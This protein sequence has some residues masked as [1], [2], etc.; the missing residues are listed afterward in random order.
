[1]LLKY[2]DHVISYI[3]WGNSGSHAYEAVKAGIWNDISDFLP[4]K[5]TKKINDVQ[6]VENAFFRMIKNRKGD[7]IEDWLH[8]S[9]LDDPNSAR[10]GPKPIKLTMNRPVIE[11]LPGDKKAYFSW[12]PVE[13]V[14]KY[15]FVL[16]DSVGVKAEIKTAETFVVLDIENGKIGWDV[17]CGADSVSGLENDKDFQQEI[18]DPITG[19]ILF[20]ALTALQYL[21]KE[22]KVDTSIHNELYVESIKARK[23]TRMLNLGYLNLSKSFG[24]DKVHIDDLTS[25]MYSINRCWAVSVEVLNHFYGGNL[26]QDEIVFGTR[27]KE[28][29]RLFSDANYSGAIYRPFYDETK[30]ALEFA[31]NPNDGN[32][33]IIVERHNETPTYSFVKNEIDNHR[34]VF[35]GYNEDEMVDGAYPGHAMVIYGYVGN[36]NNYAYLYAFGD[37]DGH[38]WNS[39][40]LTH[41]LTAYYTITGIVNNDV[42]MSDPLV[43]FDSDSDGILDFDEVYRFETNPFDY[44]SDG[45]GVSDKQ[46][47][48]KYINVSRITGFSDRY[49]DI[50]NEISDR[51]KN[52]VRAELDFDDN[53]DGLNDGL[54]DSR[55]KNTIDDIPQ[56]YTLY[57]RDHLY[58]NDGVSC[59]DETLENGAYCKVGGDGNHIFSYDP[60]LMGV[61]LGARAHVGY[62]Y[63]N[64]CNNS[65]V[66]SSVFLRNGSVVHE[67]VGVYVGRN[68]S[69]N[70]IVKQN[71]ATVLG[72]TVNLDSQS[73][74]SYGLPSFYKNDNMVDKVVKSGESF[75]LRHLDKFNKLIVE[76][77]GTL[78]IENGEMYVDSLLQVEPNARIIFTKPGY[79]SVL[80]LNG[81]IL[82]KIHDNE[83]FDNSY[84]IQVAKG[85]KLIQHSSKKMYIEG[86]WAGTIYAP[87][88]E[89]ILGQT[90]KI[91]YGRFLGKDVV[92]HQ[93]AKVYR[94]DFS[95]I[96]DSGTLVLR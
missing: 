94:V 28:S 87:L 72:K 75:Y 13:N 73:C 10:I 76:N 68:L 55:Y 2:K 71:G 44:D 14:S 21:L 16:Y 41:E 20:P 30:Y 91:I 17:Y 9:D 49:F 79:K 29:D 95:P 5:K 7:K 15:F 22:A 74:N 66:D 88:S 39:L 70:Y 80:H 89:L 63:V 31:L 50:K 40:G 93:Y 24:W 53:G 19:E 27:F 4:N 51:N 84:E 82:W 54:Y 12:V 90:S 83:S 3:A 33:Q 58:I 67:D 18:R 32:H 48:Y 47:I 60:S 85:F 25:D 6:F 81:R 37:N 59:Y 86:D 35:V 77:G 26:T 78:F 45:D 65:I 46:E 8:F 96:E 64:N 38:K 42:R 61:S 23:D 57:A 36:E 11:R 43:R 1:M 92:V 62:V 52:K 56:S 69:D 34:L